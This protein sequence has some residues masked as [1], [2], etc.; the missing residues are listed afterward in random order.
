MIR[1]IIFGAAMLISTHTAA[2]DTLDERDSSRYEL[3]LKTMES[4]AGD[5]A[6]QTV[7]S[8]EKLSPDLAR[9]VVEFAYG[10]LI[11]SDA[12]D[13]KTRE[14]A[15]VAALAGMGN[16]YPELTFHVNG[17]LNVGASSEEIVETIL[18]T[19]VYTGFP[20]SLNAV[21][22]ARGVFAERGIEVQVASSEQEGSRRDRGMKALERISG[23]S[24]EEVV[25]GLEDIAPAL[26][27][28]IIDFSYGDVLSRPGLDDRTRELATIAMLTAVG[29]A[30]PQLKVHVNAALN[31]GVTQ[32]EVV[33]VIIQMTGYAGF[34]AAINAISA[35]R[36]VFAD[37][38]EESVA[39]ET[40]EE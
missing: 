25:S 22:T 28:F 21:S 9:F 32:A 3:G 12:L 6:A 5:D 11:A 24:G 14:L 40:R 36:E 33:E 20:T 7:N 23:A 37:R 26:G 16:A 13:L 34:P 10:D 1:P 31:V 2:S 39:T 8:L 18:L 29:T 27:D 38:A 4:V 17:A 15:T 19:A 30:T 35:A